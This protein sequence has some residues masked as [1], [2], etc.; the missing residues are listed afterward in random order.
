MSRRI[1]IMTG[2]GG[3]G[4]SVISLATALKLLEHD[5]KVVLVSSDP[6]HTV[7]NYIE[8]KS[9]N[10][11]V[12]NVC[13]NFDLICIDPVLEVMR[14]FKALSE[15]MLNWFKSRGIDEALAYE[16]AMLPSVTESMGLLKAL[17]LY[18]NPN[19][20]IVIL[21]TVP[22]GEALRL[23]YL[24]RIV[25]S[26]HKRLMKASFT[27][28]KTA[29][30]FLSL[31][32][33]CG[34]YFS[35]MVSEEE[36]FF[37]ALEKL[38]QIIEKPEIT[39][40]RVIANPDASSVDVAIRS[41]GYAQIFGLNVDLAILNKYIPKEKSTEL[42]DTWIKNQET[43]F[44]QLESSIHPIPIKVLP[45][46]NEEL[47][48]IEKLRLAGNIIYGD[49]DPAKIFYTG[50][51][52]SIKRLGTE[53]VVEFSLPSDITDCLDIIKQGDELIIT[54][55]SSIGLIEKILPLPVMLR[56]ATP[57]RAE[58]ERGKLTIYFTR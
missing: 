15:Y 26:I 50:K 51:V 18:E 57:V 42:L 4:K 23:L 31:L 43:Y 44:K 13:K 1:I 28:A 19:Y 17:E 5:Y 12:L 46:F 35:K 10:N 30:K 52:M 55:R 38:S 45:L 54:L 2:K 41:V 20:D 7:L 29:S 25:S 39:S 40:I 56:T 58:F 6:A 11:E 3:V 33:G 32:V 8:V 27:F 24:P 14:K 48:G 53:Y 22:S 16:L 47:K 21:D 49:E 36:G 34:E 9:K 37:N